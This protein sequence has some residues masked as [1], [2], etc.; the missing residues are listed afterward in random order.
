M[1]TSRRR[2]YQLDSLSR[3]ELHQVRANLVTYRGRRARQLVESDQEAAQEQALAILSETDF[4]DGVIETA[5]AGAL[6]PDAPQ[7]ARGFVG[8]AFRVQPGGSRFECFYLRPT[9]GRA[10]D[11]LRRNHSTQ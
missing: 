9:N 11:Q 10:D 7:E 5:I 4:E 2:T 3:L 8:I 6:R 1:A